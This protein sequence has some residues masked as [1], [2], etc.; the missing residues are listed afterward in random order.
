M[1]NVKNGGGTSLATGLDPN[2]FGIKLLLLGG[3]TRLQQ[4]RFSRSMEY[5][6]TFAMGESK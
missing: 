2:E 5:A 3:C 6:Y 4:T 1:E